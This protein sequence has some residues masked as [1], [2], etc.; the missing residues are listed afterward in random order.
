MSNDTLEK[1][2]SDFIFAF[3]GVFDNDWEFT[4]NNISPEH[5]DLFIGKG[6]SFLNPLVSDE[7]NNWGNRGALLSA[8][9]NLVETMKNRGIYQE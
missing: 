1:Q 4:Q 6:G 9:R 2:L 5:A 3:E 7:G 8:Y